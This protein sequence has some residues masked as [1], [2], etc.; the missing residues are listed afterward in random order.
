MQARKRYI[1]VLFTGLLLLLL[2][3]GGLHMLHGPQ[4]EQATLA[5]RLRSIEDRSETNYERDGKTSSLHDIPARGKDKKC[6]ME[7]CFDFSKCKEGFKVFIYPVSYQKPSQLYMDIL[8]SIRE[9][10]YFTTNADEACLFVTS[11]DTLDR[12]KLSST[13]VKNIESSISKLSHWN[14][15]KNHLIFNLYSGTWPDY[16]EDLGFNMGDAILAKASFSEQYFRPR[17]DIS[18]PLFAKTHPQKGGSSG[19]LQGNNFPVQRKY[20]LAFKGKRYL[21]G[22]G[23]DT[24]NALYHL[25]N[26]VD[27]I[28][29]TTC[30]H[31]KNWQKHKDVRC[32][33]DNTEF[34]K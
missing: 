30:K 15:G 25:H 16:S 23:S 26:G 19:D 18:L 22:I 12:D 14:N 9:S 34:D 8:T 11:I 32:D 4:R 13:Y 5:A 20:L 21:F 10:R 6:R 28:L 31:G 17:F 27:I 29:L 3:Y 33:H 7:T 1:L 24:R 2:Y